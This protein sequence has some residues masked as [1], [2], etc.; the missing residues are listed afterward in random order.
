MVSLLGASI[1]HPTSVRVLNQKV[2]IFNKARPKA[3]RENSPVIGYRN[4]LDLYN[5]KY[6]DVAYFSW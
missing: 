1:L 3:N 5:T 6:Y 4:K 2:F